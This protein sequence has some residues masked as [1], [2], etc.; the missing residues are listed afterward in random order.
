MD[1]K[2]KPSSNNQPVKLRIKYEELSAKYANQVIIN[3]TPEE[4][5]LD[6]SSGAISDPSTTDSV[7]PIHTR[8]AM[9]IPAARRLA[10]ALNQTITHLDSQ[11]TKARDARAASLPKLEAK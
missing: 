5:Y 3:S 9:S 10:Q 4:I 8:V 1:T 2:V 7:I 11:N 6:F